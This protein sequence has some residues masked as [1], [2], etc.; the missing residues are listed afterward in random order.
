[1]K[2]FY[3]TL[4]SILFTVTLF[5]QKPI[6]LKSDE[7]FGAVRARQI[8]P[9]VMSGRVID[10]EAH[11]TNSKVFYVA[12]AGGGVWQ[13]NNSGVTFNPI[14]DKYTQCIGTVELDPNDPDKTI[15]VGTG[16]T[17]TRN[18]V[19]IGNGVYKTTDGGQN[20][21]HM[22]LPNS[23]RISNI[24]VNPKNSNEVLV[25]VLG[26]L[27][28]DS[29]ERGIYKTT[30]G[31]KTWKNIF[32]INPS[33][34][35]SEL[36]M[37]PSNPDILY[38]AFWEF[39]RTAF[40][41]NSGGLN[42]AL[43]KS[44]DGGRSWNKIHNGFPSGK[45]GRITVAVAPS[46]SSILYSAIE[47]EKPEDKGLYKSEDA[48]LNWKKLNGDFEL[49]VRPFYF[50][51]LVIDPKNPDII[52][53][54]GLSGYISKDGGKTFR[55][56]DGGVHSDFHDY[57][58]DPNDSNKIIV[59]T[60]GGVYRSYDGGSVWEMVKGLPL[61]QYY[62][63]SVDNR[64]PYWV[65]GGLQDNGSWVGPSKKV[66]GIKNS[67][68]ISVGYGDGFRVYP[69]PSDPNTVYSEM[70]GAE[71]IWRVDVAKSQA[72]TIKPYPI[73]GDPK[74]RFNWNAALSTSVHNPDRLYVG[75]QFVHVSEDKGETWRKLSPDL[76][77]NDPKKQLQEDSGGLSADNSGAENHCTVF[78]INESP[79]DKDIIWVG[80]DD[81]N[82]QV[83]M[84]GGKSWNNMTANLA[85]VPK[86]T[87]TYFI[88][89]S[90]FDKNTAYAVFDGHTQNDMKAYVMKTTDAGKTWNSIVG[91][92]IPV[93]ARCIK[94]DP[95][96]P[97]LLYL[98][99]EWGLYV[100]V[101]GGQN[102]AKFENNMPAVAV[103]YMAIQ[104]DE[105]ALVMATHGRG[106]IIIDDVTPLREITEEA[107][108]KELEFITVK[109]T[110]INESSMFQSFP[111]V[112]EYVGNNPTTSARIVYFMNKRHTFGKMTMAVYDMEGKKI[113]DLNPGKSKGINEVQWNYTLAPP[114]TAK[115][116]SFTFG[117]FA[118]LTVPAGDYTVKLTKGNKEYTQ[119]IALKYDENSIH[120]DEDRKIRDEKGME[121][122]NM[123]E[124][125]AYEVDKLDMLQKTAEEII[126]LIKDKKLAKQLNLPAY[127][128][129]I[130]DLRK[131]LVVTT[132]DNY[133][134]TA[135]PQLRE[136]IA[137]LYGEVAG[138]AGKP[139]GAQIGNL[140]L[141][142]S[143]LTE[144]KA[145]VEMSVKKSETLNKQLEKAKINKQIIAREN[146]GA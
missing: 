48:G 106:I 112:G 85:G 144:A 75:S 126:P 98:G 141:L 57:I 61:S 27:W 64:K 33:T 6:P 77:T 71:N 20:W 60:D 14:F 72:K 32:Y 135:E 1:M 132:G 45:L 23:E 25:G 133:V 122:Y 41:F 5:S 37:D 107:L 83:T 26:A 88:E 100:T 74:L 21:E 142:S 38:A 92:Q 40:S 143:K 24:I 93:F 113:A 86:N 134:G 76:T 87:W 129:E 81:G 121:L 62:H 28:G 95:K 52:L 11:P 55:S 138:Y 145:K 127:I 125:L 56:I 97:N 67:D 29:A 10:L 94:E 82:I 105:N 4:F 2:H 103:H 137:T 59:G 118:G 16:E 109:P 63:V 47:A 36:I 130:E 34:G 49:V 99:T 139:S 65:Y 66:G 42:S 78:T 128:K 13:T 69:H 120:S 43:Y 96:N 30:D 50:S 53:K 8:G 91:S 73:D 89:P 44:T 31:G 101:D 58:F 3:I 51:R 140:A 102:W 114:K 124:S 22:G 12:A 119:T 131:V 18:S 108:D 39:R 9:A 117:A 15:W 70:Q 90:N 110:V 123:M 111:A 19:S 136:K 79:L 115:G 7:I 46:N 104:R 68:W 84:D 116:K 146:T 54:A 17:W 35:C 80:T